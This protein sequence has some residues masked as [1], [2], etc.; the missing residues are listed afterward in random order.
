MP[1]PGTG[2]V[3]TPLLYTTTG[4]TTSATGEGT[5]LWTW[6]VMQEAIFQQNHVWDTWGGTGTCASCTTNGI[7]LEGWTTAGTNATSVTITEGLT[8]AANYV[9]GL[10]SWQQTEHSKARW[11]PRVYRSAPE[12]VKTPEEIAAEAARRELQRQE[13]LRRNARERR[14]KEAAEQRAHA[15]LISML[16]PE[17]RAEL[18]EKKHFHLTVYDKDG[19]HRVYR[20]ERGY[21]GNVKL[22]GADGQP[23]KRYC[24][25]ADSRLPHEDQMLA[26]KLL[27]ESNEAEFL[28]IANMTRLRAAA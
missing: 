2:Y 11:T 17:Q 1:D 22:L 6:P 21:A 4:S 12:R 8:T 13:R 5:T 27:L 26:Q 18:E 25:H 10:Q 19:S 14:F 24:I 16:T 23:I 3:D 15:L 7:R 20:I 9:W 28:R